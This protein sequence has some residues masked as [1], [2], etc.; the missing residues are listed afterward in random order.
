MATKLGAFIQQA[1]RGYGMS[2]TILA[3]R[4]GIS[5]TA[6]NQIERGETYDPRFSV[7]QRIAQVLGF[8]LDDLPPMDPAP[9]REPAHA[10]DAL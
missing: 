8:S 2:Q 6:M 1:R 5:K 9:R 7:I 4:V 10:G 3:Q